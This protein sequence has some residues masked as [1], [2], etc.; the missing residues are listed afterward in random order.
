MWQMEVFRRIGAGTL[1]ELF[2]DTSLANDRYIRTL[3]WRASA[4]KDWTVMS[5]EGKKALTAY[6]NGVNAWLD[7]HGDLPLPFV[8]TGLQGAGGGLAGYHPEHWT[9]I[10]T[11]TFAKVQAWSLGDNYGNELL[12]SILLKRGLTTEQIDQL[13]PPTTRRGRSSRRR[14]A[15]RTRPRRTDSS[16]PAMNRGCRRTSHRRRPRG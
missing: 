1:S 11:L 3:G 5:D 9:P 14:P 4:E 13:N 8:I 16:S 6:A 7:P 10:D 12:R 2:G 15:T